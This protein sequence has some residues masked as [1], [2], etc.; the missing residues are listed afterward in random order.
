MQRATTTARQTIAVLSPAYI[1]SAYAEAEWRVAVAGTSCQT[2]IY[3]AREGS[4]V[5]EFA[6][7]DTFECALRG[8]SF[9]HSETRCSITVTP[10]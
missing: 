6:G 10:A 4:E 5:T 3:R 7:G 1:E 8:D 2:G 9:V